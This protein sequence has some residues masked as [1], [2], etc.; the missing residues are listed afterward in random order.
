MARPPKAQMP[1]GQTAKREP[2]RRHVAEREDAE[3]VTAHLAALPVRP[4]GNRPERQA[5]EGA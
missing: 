2:T 5:A 1:R 4:D 3:G